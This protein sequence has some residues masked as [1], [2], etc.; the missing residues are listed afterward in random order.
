MQYEFIT[1]DKIY[2]LTT[3][4]NIKFSKWNK[5]TERNNKQFFPLIPLYPKQ[6][7]A[8]VLYCNSGIV[9]LSRFWM[10]TL[11][12]VN[13]ESRPNQ[14]KIQKWIR[15]DYWV[16]REWFASDSWG[17]HQ[18]H[19]SDSKIRNRNQIGEYCHRPR[20]YSKNFLISLS[21]ID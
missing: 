19:P 8:Q 14:Y 6:Q 9:N 11:L 10:I 18:I 4:K 13:R 2:S 16:I 21:L 3:R 17:I 12:R 20:G 7:N 1:W 5:R 15:P